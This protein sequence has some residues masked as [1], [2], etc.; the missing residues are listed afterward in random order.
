MA[1]RPPS[2]GKLL[3]TNAARPPS[4]SLAD[5]GMRPGSS[6][7]VMLQPLQPPNSQ[8][9]A[10]G[11][12]S[13]ADE[14]EYL[15]QLKK[16]IRR[17]ASKVAEYSA[18]VETDRR[19]ADSSSLLRRPLTPGSA[20]R[21]GTSDGQA[22]VGHIAGN[23]D[24]FLEKATAGKGAEQAKSSLLELLLTVLEDAQRCTLM[25]TEKRAPLPSTVPAPSV[26]SGRMGSRVPVSEALMERTLQLHGAV[27]PADDAERTRPMTGSTSNANPGLPPGPIAALLGRLVDLHEHFSAIAEGKRDAGDTMG[28]QLLDELDASIAALSASCTQQS[29]SKVSDAAAR[30]QKEARDATLAI[31]TAIAMSASGGDDGSQ[32]SVLRHELENAREELAAVRSQGEAANAKSATEIAAL[33]KQLGDVAELQKQ[34]DDKE[35]EAWRLRKQVVQGEMTKCAVQGGEEEAA[36][37]ARDLVAAAKM[38][39]LEAANAQLTVQVKQLQALLEGERAGTVGSAVHGAPAAEAAAPA[40]PAPAPPH[41]P[42]LAAPRSVFCVSGASCAL[43]SRALLPSFALCL[44]CAPQLVCSLYP[45]CLSASAPPVL[46]CH[47]LAPSPSQDRF[48]SHHQAHDQAQLAQPPPRRYTPSLAWACGATGRA[49][50]Q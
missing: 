9:F 31:S 7:R 41:A 46:A 44:P 10:G 11:S 20:N 40:A 19:M 45:S 35:T 3:D 43:L 29:K 33:R 37:V 50:R 5:I 28:G 2:R 30:L 23:I 21:P 22:S 8:G 25:L 1:A 49:R 24:T 6:P 34:L 32:V 39:A 36:D 38:S 12:N 42:A 17:L 27:R 47:L 13:L 15:S 16:E 48:C 4:R 26:E 18:A 14:K